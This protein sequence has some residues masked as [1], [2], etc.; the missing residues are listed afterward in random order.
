MI[1][2]EPGVIAPSLYTVATADVPIYLLDGDRPALFD[3]GFA[4]LSDLYIDSI[5]AILS[6]RQPA[7]CCLTHSHFD[8]VGAV[9]ALKKRYPEMQICAFERV[10]HIMAKPRAVATMQTLSSAAAAAVTDYGLD[11]GSLGGEFEAFELDRLL[12]EGDTLTVSDSLTVEVLETPGHTRD[13]LSYYIPEIKAL[14]ASE[15]LGIPDYTGY[16]VADFLVDYDMYMASVT[17]LNQLDVDILCLGH[18]YVYTDED[19]HTYIPRAMDY[20]K[21]FR[22]RVEDCLHESSGDIEQA[23]Q[24]LRAYEYDGKTGPK[25]PEPAYMMNLKA[26]ILAVQCRMEQKEA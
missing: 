1:I 19:A 26:R 25:Q 3:A 12:K 2:S 24:A 16:V 7:F 23:T 20:A 4:C 21:A 6:D 17:K 14:I 11:A 15:A 22:K 10:G 5:Q 18:S 13:C 8:H 9:A